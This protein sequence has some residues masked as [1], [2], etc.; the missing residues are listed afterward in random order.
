M[1]CDPGDL[2]IPGGPEADLSPGGV[3]REEP[4]DLYS[5]PGDGIPRGARWVTATE[6]GRALGAVGM[7]IS[8]Y[9]SVVVSRDGVVIMAR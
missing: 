6:G 7:V 8:G 2:A 4:G 9:D 5:T 1:C 3:P